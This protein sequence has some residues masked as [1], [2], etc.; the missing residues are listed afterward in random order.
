MAGSWSLWFLWLIGLSRSA[1]RKDKRNRT[2]RTDQMT[3]QKFIGL[4]LIQRLWEILRGAAIRVSQGIDCLE[5]FQNPWVPVNRTNGNFP[6]G[7]FSPMEDG[8]IGSM[9]W[10]GRAGRP[11]R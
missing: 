2:D 6:I 8:D 11:A 10:V 3:C 1:D 7:K 9:C 4:A 5:V